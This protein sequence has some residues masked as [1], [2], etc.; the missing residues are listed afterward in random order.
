ML[1]KNIKTA[2]LSD[3]LFSKPAYLSEGIVC[4][5][6]IAKLCRAVQKNIQIHPNNKQRFTNALEKESTQ[7]ST[8]W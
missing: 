2:Y 4:Q 6:D 7:T 3:V 1:K 5:I 8:D